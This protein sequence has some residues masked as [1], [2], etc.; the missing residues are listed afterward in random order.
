MNIKKILYGCSLLLAIFFTACSSNPTDPNSNHNLDLPVICPPYLKIGDTIGIV[1]ISSKISDSPDRCDS[2]LEVIRSWGFHLKL[3]KHLYD[4][5]G[6]WF[7]ASDE[8]RASDLQE[9]LDNKNV[10]AVI[11]FRGGYGAVRTLD[12]LNLM[13]LRKDPKWLVGY[14]DLTTI[15]NALRKIKVQSIHATMPINF[16]L[17]TIDESAISLREA[18]MGR[19]KEYNISYDSFNQEGSAEGTLVGGNLSLLTTLNGTDIDLDLTSAPT[20]LLIEDVGESIYAIDRMMQL[21]KRSG[22]LKAVKGIIFG[23]MTNIS[24]QSSWNK[25]L[26]EMLKEYTENLEIPVIFNFPSGHSYPNMSLYMGRKIRID[27]T[28]TSSK[29][30]F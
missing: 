6:G 16:K 3:G 15:H 10:R 20:I 1:N 19:L 11:F 14:S 8:E 25:S 9:M 4:K 26:N 13:Q 21:L 5:A 17:N 12:F 30:T 29:I 23:T 24:S 7:P 2:L 22:K 28:Y 18:L 27:V